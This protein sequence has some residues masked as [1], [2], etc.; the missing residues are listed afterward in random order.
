MHS[1]IWLLF[2][3]ILLGL[4]RDITF[5]DS[6][7]ALRRDTALE[8]STLPTGHTQI[9][10]RGIFALSASVPKPTGTGA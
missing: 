10:N 1:N 4:M 3:N 2:P 8:T 5:A 7:S 6:H 9:V